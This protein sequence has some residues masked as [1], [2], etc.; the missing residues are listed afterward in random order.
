MTE[1]AS[2]V[3]SFG[4]RVLYPDQAYELPAVA[5]HFWI[6]DGT[7]QLC[8][9]LADFRIPAP[10]FGTRQQE[11]AWVQER[12]GKAPADRL[13]IRQ[14]H[15]ASPMDLSLLVQGGMT[16]ISIYALHLLAR[17][18][19]DPERVSAWLPRLMAG[20]HKG[21]SEVDEAKTRR[22]ITARALKAITEAGED[23]DTPPEQ[24]GPIEPLAERGVAKRMT[25]VLAAYEMPPVEEIIETSA[26]LGEL[27]PVE[28][29]I[30]GPVPPPPKD[31]LEAT[32]DA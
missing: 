29:T 15:V 28:V 9:G 24:P 22:A 13:V 21:M 8:R 14:L 25:N 31:L 3:P 17:I 4:L 23:Q 11:M 6:I 1:E 7:W 2:S 20:W 30:E 12:L 32:E 19:K 16:G 10:L 26:C 5:R 27:Q 18:M